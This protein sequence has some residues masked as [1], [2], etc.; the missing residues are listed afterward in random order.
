MQGRVK[1]TEVRVVCETVNRN[2]IEV[3]QHRVVS[4]QPAE[5]GG[6]NQG[7]TP[8]EL[9]LGSLGSCIGVYAAHYCRNHRL[10]YAGIEIRVTGETSDDAPKRIT[11]IRVRLKTPRPIPDQFR[12][13][14]LSTAR[15]CLIHNTLAERPEIEIGL[16]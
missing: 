2:V 5:C 11:S 10:E 16:E 15:R 12:E 9:F 6:T 1:M 8:T 4:D 7:M 3:R 14:L 13:G